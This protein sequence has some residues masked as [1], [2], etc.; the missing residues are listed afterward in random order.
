MLDDFRFCI[1][2][3]SIVFL[4]TGKE[5]TTPV[6]LLWST[7]TCCMFRATNHRIGTQ[8][9]VMSLLQRENRRIPSIKTSVSGRTFKEV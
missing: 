1:M 8:R 3:S 9:L 6:F 2:S 5:E 7:S 4:T